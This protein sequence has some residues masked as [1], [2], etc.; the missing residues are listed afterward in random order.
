MTQQRIH[1]QVK[2]L[3]LVLLVVQNHGPPTNFQKLEPTTMAT[4]ADFHVTGQSTRVLV[5]AVGTP[6]ASTAV[7]EILAV[8]TN[9]AQVVL[10]VGRGGGFLQN[11]TVDIGAL[12]KVVLTHA[13]GL[14][15]GLVL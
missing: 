7:Q 5:V 14:L 11:G 6:V 2:A 1:R 9:G 4:I 10:L 3:L 15:G 8:V 13:V 12:G